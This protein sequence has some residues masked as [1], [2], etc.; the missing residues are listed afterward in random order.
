M[1]TGL[2]GRF[3]EL[4]ER[5]AVIEGAERYSYADLADAVERTLADLERA[6]LEPGAAVVLHAD[7]G[8]AGIAGFLALF[9]NRNIVV[10]VVSLTEALLAALAR[11]TSPTAVVEVVGGVVVRPLQHEEEVPALYSTLRERTAAGLVLLSSGSTGT[12]KAVVHDLDLLMAEKLDGT[13]LPRGRQ[14]VM[15]MFLLFDHIGGVNSL[16]SA[17]RIG[18][19]AVIARERTPEAIGALVQE[20]RIDLLPTSPS[21]LNLLVL[22][23]HHTRFDL[24]SIAA[25]TYGT[26]VMSAPLLARVRVALPRARLLQ[27]FGTSET[28]I[29]ATTSDSSSSTFFRLEGGSVEHRIVDGELQLRSRTQFLGYL[30]HGGEDPVTDDGW[31]RTGDLVVEGAD[32]SLQ[33]AGRSSDVINVGGEKLHPLELETVLLGSPAI[34]DCAVYGMPNSI[35]GQMVC[36]DVVFDGEHTPAQA[37]RHV[38]EYLAGRVERYKMPARVR[39]VAELAMTAR[40]KRIRGGS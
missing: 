13:R 5:T 14:H 21:F 25:V 22:G 6:G 28:G 27:T 18:A 38:A 34:R 36:A 1:R 26:E 7:F 23:G 20:H 15:V 39:P 35:T 4:G 31:F 33:I 32:G 10:P 30:G 16:L 11:S 19:A 9:L 29:A 17:L 37:R 40:F 8:I 24:S 3:R 12:P 2:I